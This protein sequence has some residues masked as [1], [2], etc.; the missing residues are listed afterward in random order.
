MT[1]DGNDGEEED[2]GSLVDPQVD[3]SM[4]IWLEI[5]LYKKNGL[6]GVIVIRFEEEI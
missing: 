5:F 1:F 4:V 3:L 6:K 2:G